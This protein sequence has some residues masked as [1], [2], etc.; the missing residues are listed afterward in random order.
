MDNNTTLRTNFA[1]GIISS[2][3]QVR[4]DWAK[5]ESS[6][7]DALNFI[8]TPSGGMKKRPGMRYLD[9]AMYII[10]NGIRVPPILV[11]FEFSIGQSYCLEFGDAVMRFWIDD[12]LIID[13]NTN[14]PYSIATPFSWQQAKEMTFAQYKDQLY[15]THW[16][17]PIRTLTRGPSATHTNWYWNTLIIDEADLPQAPTGLRFVVDGHNGVEYTVTSFRNEGG[18]SQE[19]R[20]ANQVI[21]TPV[22]GDPISTLPDWSGDKAQLYVNLM[23]WIRNHKSGWGHYPGF[24]QVDDKYINL[25]DVTTDFPGYLYLY[26]NASHFVGQEMIPDSR[27]TDVYPVDVYSQRGGYTTM[28]SGTTVIRQAQLGVVLNDGTLRSV[29]LG[30]MLFDNDGVG[31]VYIGNGGDYIGTG[32]GAISYQISEYNVIKVADASNTAAWFLDD[33]TQQGHF[34]TTT[35][36]RLL[37]ELYIDGG[38]VAGVT[39]SSLYNSIVAFVDQFTYRVS[40][41]IAWN[42]VSG[43]SGYF[44][45][46]RVTG[47]TLNTG[48]YYIGA[49]EDP[50]ITTFTESNI[51]ETVPTLTKSPIGTSLNFANPGDYPHTCTFH[52]QRFVV[53]STKNNPLLLGGSNPGFFEDFAEPTNPLDTTGA[54]TFRLASQTAN[55]IKHIIPLRNLYVLTEGGAFVSTV[56][57]GINRG[58]VNFNQEAFNGASDVKPVIVDR[59]ALYIPINNQMVNS[60]TYSYTEDAFVDNNLLFAAQEILKDQ[61]IISTSFLRPIINL[62]C[63]STSDGRLI[64]CT[65]IPRQEFMAWTYFETDGIIH[66]VQSITN[67]DGY[68]DLYAVVS[69][70]NKFFI[71]KF[72]DMRALYAQPTM[73]NSLYLDSALSSDPSVD[74]SEYTTIGGL[75]HL[76]GRKVYAL[77]DMS[78]QGPFTVTGGAVTL[79]QPGKVVHIGLQYN[80]RLQTLNLEPYNVVTLKSSMRRIYRAFVDV[81]KTA[82]LRYSIN[83][84]EQYTYVF[85]DTDTMGKNPIVYTGRIDL[86]GAVKDNTATYI[87]FESDLPLPCEITCITAEISY[88][89]K[90]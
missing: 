55:P 50:G 20:G 14:A 75:S 6:V 1:N 23:G 3:I 39:G 52:Q 72:E 62:Y 18:V 35:V 53:G 66:Q 77:V 68:D 12:H 44:V 83:G 74:M 64:I 48:F 82:M 7:A 17:G 67:S 69:R 32:T 87:T 31:S 24:P 46:R 86:P 27:I 36:S 61:L 58:N 90:R 54:W 8:V 88:A 4:T 63:A 49:I 28:P 43:V 9:D 78:V 76:E 21:T 71:E 47:D 59:S 65:F 38:I 30:Y 73:A 89:V 13:P 57:G 80:S 56:S 26:R 10:V 22:L 40:N 5:F 37:M 34:A 84:G 2:P 45:Y 51:G 33:N 25:M 42:A 41:T 81:E 11:P 70:D 60:L 29:L 15:C 79:D 85:Q 19:S 16:D